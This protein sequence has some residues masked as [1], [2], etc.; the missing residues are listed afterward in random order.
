MVQEQ[1]DIHV[2]K[3]EFGPFSHTIYKDKLKTYERPKSEIGIHQNPRGE[4]RSNLFDLDCS[5][6]SQD[7]SV[8]ARETKTKRN[9]WDF[10]KIQSFCTVK[11]TINKTKRQATEWE[12][13]FENDA[14]DKG[15]VSK[16][17]KE[18]KQL[19]TQK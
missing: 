12:K 8:K 15:L 7:T 2:Q 11:E 3:N 14:F 5:N 17:Y 9:Y 19:N 13:I 16:I 4:Q 1:L 18:L 10:T 6:F